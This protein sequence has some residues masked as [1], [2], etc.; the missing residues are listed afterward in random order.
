MEWQNR[1]KPKCL[2]HFAFGCQVW[3]N[4]FILSLISFDFSW[5]ILP[6]QTVS[7]CQHPFIVDRG[8]LRK[9][10]V[11]KCV[12]WP[13]TATTHQVHSHHPQYG[14]L[15][16]ACPQT[17][18]KRDILQVFLHFY[19]LT[20]MSL[21]EELLPF[22]WESEPARAEIK[23]TLELFHLQCSLNNDPVQHYCTNNH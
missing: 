9:N 6:R 2:C 16:G 13:A 3:Q 10:D 22:N 8:S 12:D 7:R 23:Y 17:M 5:W 19:Y 1:L 11:Q 18:R 15:E 21:E 14:C 20:L 4:I